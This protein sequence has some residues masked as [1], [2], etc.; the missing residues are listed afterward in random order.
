MTTS[1]PSTT[2][3]GPTIAHNENTRERD[4]DLLDEL[5]AA[6]G[7]ARICSICFEGYGP[8]QQMGGANC[9]HMFH[10]VCLNTWIERQRETMAREHYQQP[11]T[12][13]R[14]R[15]NLFDET[16]TDETGSRLNEPEQSR[17]ESLQRTT[18]GDF[19]TPE[20]NR[21]EE[22]LSNFEVI[23][24]N[25]ILLAL[26]DGEALRRRRRGQ[27]LEPLPDF[28]EEQRSPSATPT[29]GMYRAGR[30]I[31]PHRLN[32]RHNRG[33]APNLPRASDVEY[34]WDRVETMVRAAAIR[35]DTMERNMEQ[36]RLEDLR[37]MR[38]LMAILGL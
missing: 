25:R 8:N 7:A 37:E 26:R 21:L 32:F 13:P 28:L 3:N 34:I 2:E 16:S 4:D 35:R 14:C 24:R 20:N 19:L 15:A 17:E 12:C 9:D 23:A 27:R 5:Q 38:R 18:D 33:R 30:R 6:V 11:I 29:R 22:Q 36:N 10:D 1:A 31:Q